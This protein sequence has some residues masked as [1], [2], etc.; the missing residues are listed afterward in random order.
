MR[1]GEFIEKIGGSQTAPVV[2]NNSELSELNYPTQSFTDVKLHIT[3][4]L[5]SNQCSIPFHIS[6]VRPL[7]TAI[8]EE[9]AAKLAG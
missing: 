5:A 7:I 4:S 6:A 8:H 3:F 2:N 9:A 1:D